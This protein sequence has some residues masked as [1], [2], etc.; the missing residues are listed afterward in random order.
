MRNQIYDRHVS[1]TQTAD[2][3]TTSDDETWRR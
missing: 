1:E 2:A 3:A